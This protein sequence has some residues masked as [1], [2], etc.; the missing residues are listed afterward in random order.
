MA[1]TKAPASLSLVLTTE[2]IN[3]ENGKMVKRKANYPNV[4]Y[5]LPDE[6]VYGTGQALETLIVDPVV[7]INLVTNFELFES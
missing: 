2:S 5:N 7:L 6:D 1:V 4:K 3:T